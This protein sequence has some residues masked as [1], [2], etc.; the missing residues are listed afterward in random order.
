ML[1][2]EL[3]NSE[4]Y[5]MTSKYGI[6]A[7]DDRH[8]ISHISLKSVFEKRLVKLSGIYIRKYILGNIFQKI[9]ACKCG[10]FL[11]VVPS[12]SSLLQLIEAYHDQ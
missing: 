2:N 8:V 11:R 12:F 4:N 1:A 10:V 7:K 6:S 5:V 3:P 9:V